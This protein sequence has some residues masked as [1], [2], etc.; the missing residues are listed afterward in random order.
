MLIDSLLEMNPA[1]I[2]LHRTEPVDTVT[3]IMI[4]TAQ[5]QLLQSR[6]NGS[7]RVSYQ[8]TLL[9]LWVLDNYQQLSA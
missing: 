9:S 7:D 4:I 6:P 1:D 5:Y 3:V 2:L 8:T